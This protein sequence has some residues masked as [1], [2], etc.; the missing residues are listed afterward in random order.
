MS[1]N[2]VTKYQK[3]FVRKSRDAW[4]I[5]RDEFNEPKLR[6]EEFIDYYKPKDN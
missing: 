5:F 2:D 3:R 6:I 1:I 4:N